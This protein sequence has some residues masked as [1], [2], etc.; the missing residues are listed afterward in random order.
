MPIH[1]EDLKVQFIFKIID[2][3]KLRRNTKIQRFI[4]RNIT[5]KKSQ[6]LKDDPLPI[7]I[8]QKHLSFS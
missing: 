7:K 3:N 2:K 5:Q 1:P 8:N 4:F 6:T